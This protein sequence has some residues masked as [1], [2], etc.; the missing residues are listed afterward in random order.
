MKKIPSRILNEKPG[1][2]GL[3]VIDFAVLGYFLILIHGLLS[4]IGFELL[5]F[6]LS[7]VF[8]VF[9]ISVRLKHRPKVI[10]D[11]FLFK[12]NSHISSKVRSL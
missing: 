7:G 2:L 9:L 4:K 6:P 3:T 12:V 11:Y 1:F 10:R 8:T 5:A